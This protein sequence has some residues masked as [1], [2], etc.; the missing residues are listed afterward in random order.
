MKYLIYLGHPAQYHFF[1]NIVKNLQKNH[2]VK[3]LIKTKEILE[4]LLIAD[5]VEYVNIL[6]EGRK[7]TKGGIVW[8]LIKRELKV[9]LEAIKFKPDLMMGSDPSLAHVGYILRIPV[10]TVIEDDVDVIREL[11]KITYPFTTYILAP[12][13]CNCGKWK[14]KKISYSGYMKLAYLHPNYF[15]I[16]SCCDEKFALIRITSLD[17]YH[18]KNIKGFNETII[19]NTMIPIFSWALK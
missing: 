18:D 10:L 17:A 11:A 1:K 6:P 7:S 5:D 2:Q 16:N 19:K 9:F 8:G 15:K 12:D 14:R 4:P 3:Y 13:T